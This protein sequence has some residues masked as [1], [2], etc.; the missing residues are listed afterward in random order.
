MLGPTCL[1]PVK[2]NREQF[3]RV[4]GVRHRSLSDG[5]GVQ[6]AEEMTKNGLQPPVDGLH[7]FPRT[8]PVTAIRR[9]QV[10]RL[11]R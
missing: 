1:I 11:S 2:D 5:L 8:I 10:L 7:A 4:T 3:Q 9:D 6:S